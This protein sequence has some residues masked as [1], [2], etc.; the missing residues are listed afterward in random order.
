MIFKRGD[1]YWYKFKFNGVLIRESTKQRNLR[2]AERM[3][4][5]RKTQLAKGEVGIQDVKP[6]PAFD[7]AM[8]DFLAWSNRDNRSGTYRRY[9]VSSKALL[10]YFK[11]IRV[12]QITIEV[13]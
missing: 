5:A 7:K 3:E 6:V 11:N 2:T 8:R 13:V 10:R 9:L 4:A 12:N 1:K